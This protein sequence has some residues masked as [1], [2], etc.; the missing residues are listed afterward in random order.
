MKNTKPFLSFLFWMLVF[1]FAVRCFEW[2]LLS[3]YQEQTWRQ[4]GLCARGFCYDLVFFSKISL[5]LFLIHWLIYRRSE[6][7]ANLTLR[8]LGTVMLLISNAI[9]M[10]YVSANIPLDKVFFTY[11]IKVLI[12]ISKSTGAF[13]WWGYVGLLLIPTLFLVVSKKQV[14]LGKP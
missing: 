14:K 2:A 5:V 11:S 10:Y 4:L 8:I 7:A 13:V 1:G 12:Y 3:H 6:K 9:I